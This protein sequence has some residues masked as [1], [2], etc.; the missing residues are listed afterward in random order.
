M[1]SVDQKDFS[2][3]GLPPVV[4]EPRDA[5]LS[6]DA[7]L[8][9]IRQLDERQGLTARFAAALADPRQ[10][11]K[12]EHHYDELVRCRVYG[13]LADDV[14]RLTANSSTGTRTITTPCDP[15]RCSS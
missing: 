15:N 14:E 1:Q 5:Q 9:P 6:S 7:G 13:I 11:A 10:A 2:F 4:V 3:E 8:L 12:V